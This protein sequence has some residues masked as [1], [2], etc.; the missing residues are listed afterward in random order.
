ML[1]DCDDC[2]MQDTTACQDCV[3][4][5]LLLDVAGPIEVDAEQVEALEIM[6]DAGLVP[7]LRLVPRE[8]TG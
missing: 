4:T 5:H 3:V 6:A 2:A 8:A 1:I 7:T